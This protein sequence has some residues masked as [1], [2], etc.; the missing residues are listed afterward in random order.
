ME[1]NDHVIDEVE[2]WMT[3]E[4]ER[5]G[6]LSSHCCIYRV[7][8]RLRNAKET[9]YTPKVVS[10]GPLHHGKEGLKPMEEH[11]KRYLQAFL[12]RTN[13]SLKD[14]VKIV[15]EREER[16]RGCYDQTIELSSK[17]FVK[18]FV[19]DTIF[20]IE[21]LVRFHFPQFLH[22]GD[23]LFNR[24]WMLWDIVPD[25]LLL[26]NQLP[27]FIIEE[28]LI[29]TKLQSLLDMVKGSQSSTSSID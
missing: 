8:D 20:I 11:K 17:E 21:V 13:I 14:C 24:P 28:L 19:L 9:E 29:P 5:L 3:K 7:P 23:R 15:K 16:L 12:L 10:I 1:E 27:F 26:E 18:I 2:A 4:I 25:L 22:E 6:L